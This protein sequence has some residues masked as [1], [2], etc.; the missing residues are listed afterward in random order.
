MTDTKFDIKDNN[1]RLSVP[2]SKIDESKRT[3]YG[4]ATL[5]NVD[6]VD[7]VVLADASQRAF[8]S[9]RGNIREMHDLKAVGR[10]ISFR[11]EQ[12]YDPETQRCITE[13]L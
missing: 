13:S 5:D 8:E 2:F 12:Y 10:M 4:F 3:V 9:F 6:K 7:D 11:P 1:L